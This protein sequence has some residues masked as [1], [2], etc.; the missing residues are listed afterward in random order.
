MRSR[1]RAQVFCV[2]CNLPVRLEST[3]E[4]R[5][6]T[7]PAHAAPGTPVQESL[8]QGTPV[9]RGASP[10]R[11]QQPGITSLEA[12]QHTTEQENVLVAARQA[13]EL[14]MRRAIEALRLGTTPPADA[15]QYLVVVR[16]AALA[17]SALKTCS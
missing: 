7:S 11:Q 15:Q 3:N 6:Q 16:E 9:R 17:L 4:S 13:T 12:V 10:P 8:V 5:R 1:D 14:Q 2:G